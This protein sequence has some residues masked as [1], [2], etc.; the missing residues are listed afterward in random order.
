MKAIRK[1]GD[2]V[3]KRI[4]RLQH[5]NLGHKQF[6]ELYYWSQAVKKWGRW[7]QNKHV[8]EQGVPPLDEKMKV[9]KFSLRENAIRTYY[10]VIQN[11]YLKHLLV[12][13]NYFRG[14]KLLDIGCGPFPQVSVFT[15][16]APYGVDQLIAEYSRLGFPMKTWSDRMNYIESGAEKIPVEDNFFDAVISVNAIDHVD[17]FGAVAAEITRVLRPDGIL[18][19]EVHY[20]RAT[21]CEPWELC[22]HT[23][24]EH[25]GHHGLKK[26][27]ERSFAE[28]VK[29]T[30]RS[31]TVAIW[32]N[33]DEVFPDLAGDGSW[34]A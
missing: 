19:L 6:R 7:Y 10:K 12:P 13:C 31:G 30:T 27:Y 14:R 28:V 22:D 17:D 18:R 3:R 11:R 23:I 29:G 34:P 2:S 33:R 32:S 21:A 20:H 26:I 15:D 24:L 5:L 4:F 16:C 8:Q 1:L 25:Y 9:K